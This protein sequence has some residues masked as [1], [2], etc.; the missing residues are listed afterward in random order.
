MILQEVQETVLY[1]ADSLLSKDRT[2]RGFI[3]PICGNG[4]KHSGDGIAPIP[5]TNGLFKCFVCGHSGDLISFIAKSE[6]RSYMET[7]KTLAV[8][9]GIEHHH[10]D[11]YQPIM[12]KTPVKVEPVDEPKKDFTEYFQ[13]VHTLLPKDRTDYFARRALGSATINHFN[14]GFDPTWQ[15]PKILQERGKAPMSPRAIIPISTFSY[16]AR[17]VRS[18]LTDK[19]KKYAKQKVGSGTIFNP[20]ALKDPYPFIVEGEFDA[21]SFYEIGFD[22]I[23]LGSISYSNLLFAYLEEHHI[24][25]Q[26]LI[27]ALDND[28][29]GFDAAKVLVQQLAEKGYPVHLCDSSV[30]Y[31]N[32]KDANEF[33]V[34]DRSRFTQNV[35]D[36]MERVK[37][38]SGE[39]ITTDL[40]HIDFS[41]ETSSTREG[42]STSADEQ[43]K[44]EQSSQTLGDD[45]ASFTNDSVPSA[46]QIAINTLQN[47]S[48]FSQENIFSDKVLHAA[49]VCQLDSPVHFLAFR[50][51]CKQNKLS[52]TALD[53]AVKR[54][55]KAVVKFRN[56]QQLGDLRGLLHNVRNPQALEYDEARQATIDKLSKLDYS[57]LTD[58]E[59][60]QREIISLIRNNVLQCTRSGKVEATVKNI[61]A[62]L[63]YDPVVRDCIGWDEFQHKFVAKCDLPW[64]PEGKKTK[65]KNWEDNDDIGFENYVDRNYNGFRNSRLIF[66][67]LNEWAYQHPTHPVREYLQS[68]TWDGTP[69]LC[70]FFVDTLGV[71]DSEYVHEVTAC[72]FNAAIA[73]PFNPGCKWDFCLVLKGNQGIGKSTVLSQLAGQWFNDSIFAVKGKDSME[74]L[75][76]SWIVELDEMEALSKASNESIKSYISR[77]TDR[78]RLPYGRRKE[79]FA[80]QCVFAATTNNVTFLR[81]KTG[82][83][84]FLILV[85]DA[86]KTSTS[87]RLSIL[88]DDY[89]DQVWAEAY[90]YYQEMFRNGFDSKKLLPAEDVLDIAE[91]FQ[92]FSTEG[93]ELEGMIDAYLQIPILEKD[94]WRKM[95]KD[96][97]KKFVSEN[98]PVDEEDRTVLV[99]METGEVVGEGGEAVDL[100]E[101]DCVSAVEI[102]YEL[103]GVDNPMR[104]RQ[105]IKE[106]TEIMA[107]MDGWKQVTWKRCGVYGQQRIAFERC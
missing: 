77:Q 93:S 14:L 35:I 72:W 84:R 10:G 89:V 65:G 68:L 94:K 64:Y 11:F 78:F 24:T 15:H 7:A 91:E 87:D 48:D 98:V 56:Q 53:S 28:E 55:M 6:N 85:S 23:A 61:E 90:F 34:A 4:S 20:A 71:E 70:T 16:L 107:R 92:K 30:L 79:E 75:I 66:A 59:D 45:T 52:V 63:K 42:V 76:G 102:A 103:F 96:A 57:T 19:Q 8:Q 26:R 29:R 27:V 39:V 2:G 81:D 9:F 43:P 88:T 80:R 40:Q 106:I 58:D 67:A 21:M 104:D 54:V 74:N 101:R 36:V 25:P 51:K 37:S 46:L 82:G 31:D 17:D 86:D 100:V 22:A 47:V 97:R 3:C 32:H 5:N 1:H 18:T 13:Y 33:L 99:N 44:V 60:A 41:K 73:R 95:T 69:R 38:F 12:K 62:I 50:D 49:A 105:L 83:R